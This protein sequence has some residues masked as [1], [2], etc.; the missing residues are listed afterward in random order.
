MGGPDA[1]ERAPL[2][3]GRLMQAWLDKVEGRLSEAEIAKL[4]P[5]E[6]LDYA[7]RFDQ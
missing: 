1:N 4:S 2:T 5:A 7:R 3:A 6:R